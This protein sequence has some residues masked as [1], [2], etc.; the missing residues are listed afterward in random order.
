MLSDYDYQTNMESKN[1]YNP[2]PNPANTSPNLKVET[3]MKQAT[4]AEGADKIKISMKQPLNTMQTDHI[5]MDHSA[6]FSDSP[7]A[8][9][10]VF[11]E[12]G[13]TGLTRFG[14]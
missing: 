8:M 13:I 3:P 7:D 1:Q 5:P 9:N 6:G 11:Y 12:H 2:Q 10:N 14:G 4:N